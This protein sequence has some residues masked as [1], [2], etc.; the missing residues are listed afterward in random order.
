MDN[1]YLSF[2]VLYNLIVAIISSQIILLF[3]LNID[4]DVVFIISI[5]LMFI[6]GIKDVFVSK[7]N[8]HSE[9]KNVYGI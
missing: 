8:V 9:G 1:L 2:P 6:I 5:C 7:K 4:H 3:S